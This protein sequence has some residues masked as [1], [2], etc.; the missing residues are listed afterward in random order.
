MRIM[1]LLG[2]AL[3]ACCLALAPLPAAA[4]GNVINDAKQLLREHKAE[5]AYDLLAPL[6]SQRA[7][8]PTYDYLLGLAA[9]ESGRAPEAIFAFQRVLAVEPENKLARAQIAR[10]YFETGDTIRA[11]AQFKQVEEMGV[12]PEVRQALTKYLSAIRESGMAARKKFHAYLEATLGYDTNVNSATSDTTV[13]IPAFAGLL[14][15]L[16]PVGVSRGDPYL[17]LAG[18]FS[19]R[20]PLTPHIDA[21]LGGSGDLKLNK[22]QDRFDTQTLGGYFGASYLA[23]RYTYTLALQGENFKVDK[24]AFRDAL[25]VVGQVSRQIGLASQATAYVQATHLDYPGQTIRNANRYVGGVGYSRLLA[26]PHQATIY[27]GMYGGVEDEVSS[28][29]PW[30]GHRLIGLRVGGDMNVLPK[31]VAFASVNAEFRR[32]GGAEPLFLKTRNERRWDVIGG[33]HYRP[34]PLWTITPEV[35]YTRNDS[36]IPIYSFDRTLLSVTLRRDFQ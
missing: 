26:G 16:N 7:G 18:G 25:G 29:V 1:H 28:G 14:F 13:A 24:R 22:S 9:L 19:V 33:I 36:N 27:A 8:E 17:G 10:A 12:P 23:N 11:E 4:S 21:V 3:L 31:T 35:S 34:A 20:E 6:Q 30:L 15:E 32:Y 2:A 5:Q